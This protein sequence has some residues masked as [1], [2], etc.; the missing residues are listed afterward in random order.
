MKS[1]TASKT[2]IHLSEGKH[3]VVHVFMHIVIRSACYF[4]DSSGTLSPLFL[5]RKINDSL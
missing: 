3:R 5:K 2:F 1:F 4:G